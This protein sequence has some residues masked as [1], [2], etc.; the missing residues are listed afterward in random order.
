MQDYGAMIRSTFE[1]GSVRDAEVLFEA[2]AV[3]KR[4]PHIQFPPLGADPF[5]A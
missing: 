3:P 5:P 1:H 2:C 4:L